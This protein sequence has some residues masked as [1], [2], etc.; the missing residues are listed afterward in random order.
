MQRGKTSMISNG[1]SRGSPA[2][3]PLL[4]KGVL[5][6]NEDLAL[7]EIIYLAPVRQFFEWQLYIF[8]K[9]WNDF[10]NLK[11]EFVTNL[12]DNILLEYY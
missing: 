5:L 11:E 7:I 8:K 10:S 2:R 6:Q 3:V 9:G 1:V 12:D 4:K